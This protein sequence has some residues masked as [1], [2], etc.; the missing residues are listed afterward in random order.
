MYFSG[1]TKHRKGPQRT[2]QDRKVPQKDRRG[3]NRITNIYYFSG[4]VLS[5]AV[6]CMAMLRSQY[7]AQNH[8]SQKWE[9][10]AERWELLWMVVTRRGHKLLVEFLKVPSLVLC[11][12][13]SMLTTYQNGLNQ[14]WKCSQAMSSTQLPPTQSRA[15]TTG[16]RKGHH[17][18]VGASQ[19]RHLQV[20]VQ[21][22]NECC[23][24]CSKSP[25]F[26]PAETPHG[27]FQCAKMCRCLNFL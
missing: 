10:D 3:L 4:R 2:A 9:R 6:H 21:V 20:Q 11:Y 5:S 13:S 23:E 26:F 16:G 8:G 22:I 24:H 17:K 18:A 1:T 15:V 19:V 27:K 14:K 12:F 25:D 7:K